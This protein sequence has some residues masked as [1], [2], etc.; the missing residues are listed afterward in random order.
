[1]IINTLFF[2]LDK[3]FPVTES[4]EGGR[5]VTQRELNH[6][7]GR[8][9]WSRCSGRSGPITQDPLAI[10]TLNH[11]A[12]LLGQWTSSLMMVITLVPDYWPWP[13]KTPIPTLLRSF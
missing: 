12:S 11:T 2:W 13:S 7:H 9:H 5:H 4:T 6:E 8:N 3:I 1:M 10:R